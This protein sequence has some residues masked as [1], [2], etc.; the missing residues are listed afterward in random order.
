[1]EALVEAP[2][3]I[4]HQGA[5]VDRFTKICQS[6]SL[7]LHLA[8]VLVDRECPL[9]E[10]AEFCVKEQSPRLTVVQELLLDPEP[11]SPSSG[12]AMSV[13]DIQEVQRDA[14]EQPREDHIIHAL[15]GRIIER[16]GVAEDMILQGIPAKGEEEVFA[17]LGIFGGLDVED[18]GHQ[19]ADVLHSSS[20]TVQMGDGFSFGVDGAVVVVPEG[21]GAKTL[22][23]GRCLLL[24]SVSLHTLLSESGSGGANTLLG[25]SGGLEE[26]NFLLKLLAA[27]DIVGMDG[28]S[29][30]FQDLGRGEGFITSLSRG[31][32]SIGSGWRPRGGG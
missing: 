15:P 32:S 7:A 29:F 2:Q 9:R 27:L 24:Q 31:G 16:R 3:D 19:V 30:F 5:V 4:Q 22:A 25:S 10:V 6:V 14:V 8:A 21:L 11:G 12:A 23:E 28:G 26:V 20:L 1:M 17:P 13:D 18:D